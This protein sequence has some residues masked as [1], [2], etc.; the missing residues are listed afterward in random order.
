MWS[1][2]FIVTKEY[3]SNV[4]SKLLA[5][6]TITAFYECLFELFDDFSYLHVHCKRSIK[7]FYLRSVQETLNKY[8]C[9]IYIVLTIFIL[10]PK[11]CNEMW[12]YCLVRY[13]CNKHITSASS[14]ELL[15]VH[16]NACSWRRNLILLL[17]HREIKII[18]ILTW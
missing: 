11:H 2:C 10:K 17:I 9:T 12:I 5:T 6:T 3:F 4:V 15:S 8:E 16:D 18:T 7:I 13:S 14:L 1:Y